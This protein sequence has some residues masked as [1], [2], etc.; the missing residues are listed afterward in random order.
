MEIKIIITDTGVESSAAGGQQIT[1]PPD[2]PRDLAAIVGLD[3]GPAPNA[4]ASTQFGAPAPFISG[5]DLANI[6]TSPAASAGPAA[7]MPIVPTVVE[8]E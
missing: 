3:A 4:G 5:N 8:S 6:T 7:A 1:P 2:I